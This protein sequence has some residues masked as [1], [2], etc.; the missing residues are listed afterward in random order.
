MIWASVGPYGT[1]ANRTSTAGPGT[2]NAGVVPACVHLGI[3]LQLGKAHRQ[4]L[5]EPARRVPALAGADVLVFAGID[6]EQKRVY[7]IGGK[8]RRS[9]SPRS[10]A[11]TIMMG[12]S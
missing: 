5:A 8:V 4:F 1:V 11:K 7:G 12:H 9:D 10:R 2:V 3:V 6:S